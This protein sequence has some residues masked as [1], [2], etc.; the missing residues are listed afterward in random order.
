MARKVLVI[1]AQG[2]LGNFIARAFSEAKWEATRAGR[3]PEKAPDFRQL[4]LADPESVR[5]A[6]REVDLV[7]S[8]AHHPELILETTVLREGGTLIDLIELSESERARLDAEAADPEGLVVIHTG[9]G[10]VAYLAIADLLRENPGAD[11]AEYAL[12]FSAAGSSGRA[13]GLFAHQLLTS[14]SH[15]ASAAVPFPEPFGTRDCLEVGDDT[16]GVPRAAVGTA[17]VRHYLCMQP[18]A[19]NSVLRALNTARLISALPSASFTAGTKKLPG[20]LSQERICEWVAVSRN[21]ERLASQAMEGHGYYR[22]TLAATLVFAEALSRN[23]TGHSGVQSIDELLTLPELLPALE[24]R[25]IAVRKQAS[26][27]A[28]G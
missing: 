22:M 20:E 16:D 23:P 26:M 21:G 13:A 15:H 10:G 12:M 27:A 24:R 1:G 7:V 2:V 11:A 17:P 9:L 28:E 8:T 4:D 5:H 6:C 14:S 25:G 3:R 19:L 18:R